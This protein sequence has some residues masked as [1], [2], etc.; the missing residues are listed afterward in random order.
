MEG[1]G[2]LGEVGFSSGWD[3]HEKRGECVNIC[4]FDGHYK[5][6]NIKPNVKLIIYFSCNFWKTPIFYTINFGLKNLR[7]Y[8]N[9]L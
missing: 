6:N 5:N 3:V 1:W 7:L 2:V 9:P 8:S 4:L